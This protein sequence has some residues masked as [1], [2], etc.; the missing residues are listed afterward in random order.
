MMTF[1]QQFLDDKLY[2]IF[3]ENEIICQEYLYNNCNQNYKIYKDKITIEYLDAADHRLAV[4]EKKTM[5]RNT[6]LWTRIK[7]QQI[8]VIFYLWVLK[9]KRN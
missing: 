7:V 1:F 6:I 8:F 5:D 3:I 9:L 2:Q 4:I